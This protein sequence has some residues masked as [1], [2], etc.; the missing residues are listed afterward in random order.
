MVV[1]TIRYYRITLNTLPNIA[2]ESFVSSQRLS[3]AL[4]DSRAKKIIT[5]FYEEQSQV[6]T[7]QGLVSV[8]AKMLT[9]LIYIFK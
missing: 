3:F 1:L 6:F 4:K 5:D 8:L 9:R 7:S 2:K